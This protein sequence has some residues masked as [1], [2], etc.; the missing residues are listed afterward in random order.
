MVWTQI[1]KAAQGH[2]C[3]I[4]ENSKK[5]EK[6]AFSRIVTFLFHTRFKLLCRFN[7]KK[8]YNENLA[9]THHTEKSILLIKI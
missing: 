7:E 5:K 3:S 6:G 8:T 4:N 9:I 1:A 2:N